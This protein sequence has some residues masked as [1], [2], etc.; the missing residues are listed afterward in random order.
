MRHA[1]H[2]AKADVGIGHAGDVGGIGHL[3]TGRHITVGALGE[4]P[5]DHADGLHRQ[6]IGQAPRARR[7]VAFN[8]VGQRVE[9]G[10]DLEPARHGIGQVGVDEGDDRD[11]MRVDGDELALVGGV[12]DHIVDGGFGRGARGGRHAEDRH[13]RVLGVRHALKAQHIREFGIGG[14]DADALARVLRGSS[15][16]TDQEVRSG[17]GEFG[18]AVLDAFDRRIRLD[19]AEH[20]IRHAGFVEHVGDL[21]GSAGLQQHRIGDDERLGEAVRLGHGWNLPDRA[22]SEICGLVENHAIYHRCSPLSSFISTEATVSLPWPTV[23]SYR[24]F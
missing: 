17:F 5:G 10:G 12:G 7:D 14:D 16:Q 11:V 4:V 20:L 6:A 22:A 8:G 1:V 21:L 3:L 2:Q 18:D 23:S 9:T 13:R 15:A 19:V 24:R